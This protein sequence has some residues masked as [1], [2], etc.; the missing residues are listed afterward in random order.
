MPLLST[1]S[2]DQIVTDEAVIAQSAAADRGLDFG[3][4]SVLRA[5]AE[6]YGSIGLWLQGLILR[7]LAAT[8]AATSR[9]TDLD[10][11]MADYGIIRSPAGAAIGQVTFSRFTPGL[12]AL[13]PVGTQVKTADGV[14]S[15]AVTGAGTGFDA[16]QQGYS[17]AP[18]QASLTLP[19]AAVTAG[20]GGN[21]ATNTLTLLASAVPGVDTVTNAAPLSGGVEAESDAA[22]QVRF[23]AY[24]GS[25]SRATRAAIDYAVNQVQAGL[26]WTVIEGQRADG[27]TA[28]ATFTLIVDDGTG[29]PQPDLIARVAA[30][31][32]L[33]RAIGIAF[34]VIGPVKFLANVSMS[35]T[36][37][38]QTDHSAAVALVGPALI[39]F[40][41]S[42]PLG[43]GLSYTRVSQVAYAASPLVINVT[44][45]LINGATSDIP[46]APRQAIRA[47][48]VAVA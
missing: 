41:N 37:A 32:E 23:V 16:V 15:Y 27:T 29:A 4:G 8:R 13:I 9:G 48:T 3:R 1:K 44:A 24:I 21:A 38:T 33:Y 25:L 30:A 42:V 12:P 34:S 28:P 40:I 6:A 35:I 45:V 36:T 2:L 22:L 47:G 7:V 19:V 26:T 10:T 20:V 5:L 46:P 39:R 17:L 14:W 11:W 43:A 31:V 18:G